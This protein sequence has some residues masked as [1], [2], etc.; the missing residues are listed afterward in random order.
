MSVRHV[1]E[2]DDVTIAVATTE[3][4]EAIA[5]SD[6]LK[7]M[8]TSPQK[9]ANRMIL[10]TFDHFTS[11]DFNVWLRSW[12]RMSLTSMY[13]RRLCHVMPSSMTSQVT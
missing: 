4:D 5:S 10:V 7:I 11:S 6:F 9:G 13:V 1:L 12:S 3:A 2:S 8:G